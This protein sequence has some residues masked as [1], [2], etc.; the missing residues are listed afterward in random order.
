MGAPS[1]SWQALDRFLEVK[2]P[3]MALIGER[4]RDDRNRLLDYWRV[5]TA[6]SAVILTVHDNHLILP[7]AMYRPGVGQPTLDFPGGR[8]P[9][10]DH[11]K[12]AVPGILEMASF[13]I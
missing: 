1:P 6:N 4:L 3:W 8:V 13:Q 12:A 5:E 10:E 9:Q 2:S 7:P 11:P